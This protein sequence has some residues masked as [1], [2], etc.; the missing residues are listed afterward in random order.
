MPESVS[1]LLPVP[2][3]LAEGRIS[4]FLDF[5][6]TLVNIADR[7]DA[8]VVPA[9]LRALIA[10]LARRLEGRLAVVSGR[11]ADEIVA[12]L[13]AGESAP[14]FA[15][16]GSHGL[17][18]RWTDGRREAPAPPGAVAAAV[19]AFR[20]LADVHSGIVVEDKPFGVA[21]H[22]R[23]APDIAPAAI[24]LAER[25]AREQGFSL[26][27]GKMVCELRVAGADKGDAVRRFLAEPP[28][29]GSRPLFLG[30]DLTDEAGFVAADALGGAGILVGGC[31]ERQ[32][33]ARYR[34]TDVAAVHDWL[35]RV[36][37][38]SLAHPSPEG[39]P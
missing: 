33:A 2:A 29:A 30:D 26:Q 16:A 20:R 25:V 11:P 36:A 14:P 7:H 15:I 32:T 8:V 24:A 34:L 27:H 5:D 39:S 18:L 38:A 9:S 22:Y 1:S 6:G 3:H 13:H 23:Q 10:A 31:G 19:D 21:L 37:D 28:M 17:E 12:Y 35:G 4:L